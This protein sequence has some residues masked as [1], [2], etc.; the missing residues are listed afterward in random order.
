[1]WSLECSLSAFEG[2]QKH[3]YVPG[4]MVPR[5]RSHICKS[6]HRIGDREPCS[7][8]KVA[9]LWSGS[10]LDEERRIY[11]GGGLIFNR[12]TSEQWSQLP[13]TLLKQGE[14]MRLEGVYL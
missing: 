10:T 3:L 5:E 14:E 4:H 13:G 7:H 8:A 12:I 1:M 2:E 11:R 6:P 9:I